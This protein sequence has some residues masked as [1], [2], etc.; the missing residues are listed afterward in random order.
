MISEAEEVNRQA[1]GEPVGIRPRSIYEL[2]GPPP[3]PWS[4]QPLLDLLSPA[5]YVRNRVAFLE[6]QCALL[7]AKCG[8]LIEENINLVWERDALIVALALRDDALVIAN[9][10][11]DGWR[12][13]LAGADADRDAARLDASDLRWRLYH[14]TARRPLWWHIGPWLRGKGQR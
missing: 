14:A 4:L 2:L 1:N 6:E 10:R 9:Q 12:D 11:G 5:A 7:D 8:G 13:A 3:G